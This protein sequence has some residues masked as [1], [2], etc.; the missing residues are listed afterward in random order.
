MHLVWARAQ[1]TTHT[2]Q[3]HTQ[4]ITFAKQK[5][6]RTLCGLYLPVPIAR[7]PEHPRGKD[8]HPPRTIQRV[9]HGRDSIRRTIH[10]R[11]PS[12]LL[13]R[14]AAIRAPNFRPPR[15]TSSSS[16]PPPPPAPTLPP[17]APP[18]PPRA[19][20]E[21]ELRSTSG[22]LRFT[23]RRAAAR[24][25]SEAADRG[26]T[27]AAPRPPRPIG[28]DT[29]RR[30]PPREDEG[31]PERRDD[32]KPPPRGRRRPGSDLED[33]GPSPSPIVSTPAR[34]WTQL[35]LKTIAA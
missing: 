13:V 2:T 29:G 14:A 11:R 20:L 1:G 5:P 7:I 25:A 21:G 30:F 24:S 15:T 23:R 19:A 3:T 4:R 10:S 33:V 8:T 12:S 17:C 32:P 35:T 27:R 9:C 16:P 6:H 22:K 18:R 28:L 34:T 26:R 31:E